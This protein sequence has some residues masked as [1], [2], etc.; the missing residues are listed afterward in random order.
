MKRWHTAFWLLCFTF[1]FVTTGWPAGAK[2]TLN[3][4]VEETLKNNPSI[5]AYEE[6][7]ARANLNIKIA[8]TLRWG[9]LLGNAAVHRS[10]DRLMVSPITPK[11]MRNGIPFEKNRYGYGVLYELPIYLGG[12]IPLSVDIS[13]LSELSAGLA[14]KR[15]RAV[16]RHRVTELYHNILSMEGE[17][18]AV[19]ENIKALNVLLKHTELAIKHGKKPPVDRYKI[20]YSLRR[21]QAIRDKI[22]NQRVSMIVALQTLMGR[23]NVDA[24]LSLEPVEIPRK[25]QPLQQDLQRLYTMALA[26][27][28]DL[29]AARKKVEIAEKKVGLARADRMPNIFAV[30]SFQGYDAPHVNFDE[31]WDASLQLRIPIFDAG[32]RRKKVE[33]AKVGVLEERMHVYELQQKII[34]EVGDAVARVRTAE[35]FVKSYESRVQLEKEVDRVETLKY[36]KGAG[37]I[38]D[39]LRAKAELAYS[40][41]KWVESMFQ[42]LNAKSYLSMVLEEEVK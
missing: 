5:R 1:C 17:Q 22:V 20:T 23:G 7:V 36:E 27:R 14:L 9:E 28:S 34:R 38:D 24:S 13:R 10:E 11:K 19:E 4:A 6:R 30:G 40:R 31:E 18:K 35:S 33:A 8:K 41:S 42:W 39:M 37:D 21:W 29:Q 3:E 32:R 15:L 25:V 2:L 16:I 26:K 12:K